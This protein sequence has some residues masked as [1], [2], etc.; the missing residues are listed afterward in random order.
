MSGELDVKEQ[1]DYD[2]MLIIEKDLQERIHKFQYLSEQYEHNS[3]FRFMNGDLAKMTEAEC[4]MTLGDMKRQMSLMDLNRILGHT[5]STF[6]RK[7]K[8]IEVAQ[9]DIEEAHEI[10][11][12][13]IKRKT[14]FKQKAKMGT[15]HYYKNRGLIKRDCLKDVHGAKEDYEKALKIYDECGD[16]DAHAEMEYMLEQLEFEID[17][18]A[19]ITKKIAEMTA[20]GSKEKEA[21][22]TAFK[23]FDSDGSGIMDLKEFHELAAELGTYPPLTEAER[24]EALKQLDEDMS[25]ELSFEEFWAWWVADEL[26]TERTK[27]VIA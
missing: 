1:A 23:K 20:E 19:T 13:Q 12:K 9:K 11:K 8:L 24:L 26:E 25:G 7:N 2:Q 27:N 6:E 16:P 21:V 17:K 4:W 15:G 3:H 18:V 5:S 10:Y 14:K 22:E